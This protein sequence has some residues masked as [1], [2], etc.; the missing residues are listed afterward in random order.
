MVEFTYRGEANDGKKRDPDAD[1]GSRFRRTGAEKPLIK[2]DKQPY[3]FVTGRKS[4]DSVSLIKMLLVGYLYGIKSERR[5]T[6]E[7]SLNSAYR[8]FCGFDLTDKIPDHSLFSQNRK[9]R[10]TDITIFRDIFN[11]IVRLCVKLEQAVEKSAVHYL[12]DLDNE[13][14]QE[15]GYAEPVA[16]K[17]KKTVM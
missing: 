6:E 4:I 14:R 11:H 8:W 17:E 3:Y 12:G 2:K 5:L 16:V 9:R 1:N 7:V 10:F 13:L 15:S